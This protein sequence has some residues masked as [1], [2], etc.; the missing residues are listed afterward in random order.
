MLL[1]RG[2]LCS[3]GKKW[4]QAHAEYLRRSK[5]SLSG[6][7]PRMYSKCMINA[8]QDC[9][10]LWFDH[11]SDRQHTTH[12]CIFFMVDTSAWITSDQKAIDWLPLVA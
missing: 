9:N 1:L 12:Q 4:I 10:L 3:V 5:L 6:K 11:I 8:P 7:L 2:L